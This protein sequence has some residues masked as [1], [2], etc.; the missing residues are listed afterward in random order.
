[1]TI[2]DRL[3]GAGFWTAGSTVMRAAA[4]VGELARSIEKDL[5]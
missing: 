2:G 1:M 3:D 5:R 4:K